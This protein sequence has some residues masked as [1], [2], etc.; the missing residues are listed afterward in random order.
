MRIPASTLLGVAMFAAMLL[1]LETHAQKN[2]PDF[3]M[4]NDKIRPLEMLGQNVW[5]QAP[6]AAQQD[7]NILR[8]PAL[9]NFRPNI[10]ALFEATPATIQ[11][12]RAGSLP[13]YAGAGFRIIRER[14][15]YDRIWEV[16]S[17][18]PANGLRYYQRVF[19]TET[20][21]VIVTATAQASRWRHAST[22]QMLRT[23]QTLMVYY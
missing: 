9:K 13:G 1:P 10:N 17:T 22:T 23:M 6:F 8:W 7:G 14:I 18:T 16:E 5:M 3:R 21:V 15:I 11:Q 20:G 19:E 2:K 12:Y 4:W